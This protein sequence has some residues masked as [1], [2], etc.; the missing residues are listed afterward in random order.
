MLS[1]VRLYGALTK[2][3]VKG[4]LKTVV[5]IRLNYDN[6]TGSDCC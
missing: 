6:R 2:G 4:V 3:Q 5:I 1:F